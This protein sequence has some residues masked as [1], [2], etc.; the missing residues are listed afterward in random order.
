MVALSEWCIEPDSSLKGK[1]NTVFGRTAPLI[2]EVGMGKGRFIIDMALK[3]P[4]ADFIGIE[5]YESVM[6]KALRKLDRR[7]DAGEAL[8][9]NLKFMCADAA[10]LKDYF[11]PKEVD[12]VF[13]NFSDPWPKDRHAKRRL[14]SRGFLS[15]FGDILKEDGEIE[16][17][18]DNRDLF[19]FGLSE[20]ES[21]GWKAVYKTFDLHSD[22][23]GMKD[24]VMTEYEVKFSSLGNKICKF[25][26][27]R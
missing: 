27:R 5:R 12:R 7:K 10:D 13:L 23:E 22:P 26:I 15:V 14:V 6:V 11:A 17:K 18:T 21:A 1:W 8:P 16:F 19:E 20:L 9:G 3:H 25:I 24:N 4:E 2:L